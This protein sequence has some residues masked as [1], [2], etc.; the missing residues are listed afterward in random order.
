M[1]K[2]QNKKG[3]TFQSLVVSIKQ[4]HEQC[5]A[6]ATKAVNVGLTLRNWVIGLYILE[7]EQGGTDRAKYGS[8]ILERLS[9]ILHKELDR[10]YTDRYLR[11]CR[12]F[13]ETYP[14]IRKS[15]ISESSLIQNWKSPIPGLPLPRR[16]A[17]AGK[18]SVLVPAKGLIRNLSFTH[19]IEFLKCDDPLKRA[20]YEHECVRG[21]WSVRELKRQMA[22]LYFER[23]GLS[24][25]KKKLAALVAKKVE[26]DA[27]EFAVRDPYVFEFLGL[28]SKEV[29]GESRLEDALLD[30]LQEFLLELGHGF[31]FEARQK[32]IMLDDEHAF[33]DLVFYH[34]VLKC[35]VLIELKTD[36][37]KYEHI[38]Q[39]NAY[40]SWYKKHA[41]A[42][43]DN[44]PIGILLCTRKN[45]A[46][47]E[48]ALAGMDNKLFVKKYQ[49]E[50]PK[51]EE[52]R[53]FLE[54][55]LR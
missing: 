21:N 35:H 14:Q 47:V 44:S 42:L 16:D 15:V 10:C 13:Y 33:V 23:S 43:G 50:L 37:F 26:I 19:F 48:Y 55:Q 46:K 51:K 31:C 41:M 5:F 3:M 49:L 11:L 36:E 6:R 18:I 4:A 22:T 7:Y 2:L 12:Q 1:G 45:H 40:V 25:N 38:G 28:K 27:P 52:I 29:M 20:F 53:K 8:R 9:V 39:L 32:R 17:M 54:A 34:R 30:R 24:K